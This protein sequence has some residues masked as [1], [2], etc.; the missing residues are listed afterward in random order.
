MTP[1][2]ARELKKLLGDCPLGIHSG[3]VIATRS[4][5]EEDVVA[6]LERLYDLRERLQ[7][8]RRTK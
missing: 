6:W 7:E 4:T 3:R 1:K 2:L 5:T 8:Q